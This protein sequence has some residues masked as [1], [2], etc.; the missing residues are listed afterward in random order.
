[1][2]LL[3]SNQIIGAMGELHPIEKIRRVYQHFHP[4]MISYQ[5]G[6]LGQ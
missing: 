3:R 2:N 5:T 6:V 4:Y 1:M